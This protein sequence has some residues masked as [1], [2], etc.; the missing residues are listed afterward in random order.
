M[1]EC[2]FRPRV[3]SHGSSVQQSGDAYQ[4]LYAH[5]TERNQRQSSPPR[6]QYSFKPKIS[7]ITRKVLKDKEK[8][9]TGSRWEQLYREGKLRVHE[10]A[11]T[12][13]P[14]TELTE[15]DMTN[16]TFQPNA[17]ENGSLRKGSFEK[18]YAQQLPVHERLYQH[19]RN[20]QAV[21]EATMS[22]GIPFVEEEITEDQES[23]DSQSR[24]DQALYLL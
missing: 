17:F 16:C 24:S 19:A 1:K 7:P 23:I 6:E 22:G 4:R 13:S 2:T 15:D 21:R 11:S 10:R 12:S 14:T 5:A 9:N 20:V 8:V 18:R 3:N